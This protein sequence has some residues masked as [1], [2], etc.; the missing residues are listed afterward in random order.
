MQANQQKAVEQEKRDG[1][2][3]FLDQKKQQSLKVDHGQT[4]NEGAAASESSCR[5]SKNAESLKDS[6]VISSHHLSSE[7]G[8]P[9]IV[10][11]VENPKLESSFFHSEN[12][13]IE[14]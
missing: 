13:S 5:S 8:N 11:V 9:P 3:D 4:K 2:Q 14:K 12:N 10:A 6:A 7:C 1:V